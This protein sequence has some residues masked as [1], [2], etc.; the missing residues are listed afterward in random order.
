MNQRERRFVAEYLID[1][2]ASAAATRAGYGGPHYPLYAHRLVRRH[3]IAAAIA[4][5]EA[6]R[7]DN[8][9][10][11]ADRV[12][13]EFSKIGFA[14]MRDFVDWGP[15][16]FELRRPASDWQGGA[17]AQ[18]VPPTNGKP[19][20]IRLHDKHAALEILARHTGLLGTG[21]AHRGPTDYRQAGRDARAIL[22][23]RLARLKKN[24]DESQS[25]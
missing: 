20:S 8:R 23:E 2:N 17:V 9:R 12:L 18:V 4:K 10:A 5:G 22:L 1:G 24:G 6:A 16:H 14:D 15:N 7:A 25:K 11:T 19:G 13:L 21:R 3:D